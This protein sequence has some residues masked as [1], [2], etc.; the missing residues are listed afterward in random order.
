M[1]NLYS[2]YFQATLLREK[3]WFVVGALKSQENLCFDRAIDPENNRF[4]F[5]VPEQRVTE[6]LDCIRLFEEQKMVTH[7]E[8][9]PNRILL[10]KMMPN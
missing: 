8:E 4:E 6:F 5:F 9:L 1:S 10:Q 2:R 3:I 7:F